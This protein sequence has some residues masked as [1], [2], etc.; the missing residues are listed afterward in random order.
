MVKYQGEMLDSTFAALADRTRRAMLARLAERGDMA[1]S[2][3]AEP[4]RMTLPAALK[5]VNVLSDAGLIQREKRGRVVHCRLEAK[6]MREAVEWLER[7]EKFWSAQLDALAAY[8]EDDSWTPSPA[9]ASPSRGASRRRSNA[10]SAP[11]PKAK[12]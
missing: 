8:V 12:R 9:Q 6:P 11:G 3:L 2:E 1:V 7:Y 4:F 10:S 5:H